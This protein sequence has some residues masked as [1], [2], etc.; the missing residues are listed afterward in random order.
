MWRPQEGTLLA[1]W[2]AATG[3]DVTTAGP[4]LPDDPPIFTEA[5]VD[6]RG[7]VGRLRHALDGAVLREVCVPSP[8]PGATVEAAELSVGRASL[9]L[10]AALTWR[11]DDTC[12]ST[13]HLWRGER[14]LD[15]GAMTGPVGVD[16]PLPIWDVRL[17]TP[18][19]VF[20]QGRSG[21]RVCDVERQISRTVGRLAGWSRDGLLLGRDEAAVTDPRT[22]EEAR[23]GEGG[24][25]TRSMS[26]DGRL[27]ALRR[28][29]GVEWWT[30]VR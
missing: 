20:T 6:A 29:A 24:A 13:L 1:A 22:G 16:E 26:P 10:A 25:Q 4:E 15:L 3:E 23:L 11:L 7:W 9:D 14:R 28:G 8:Q 18:G 19:L 21:R 2:T 27:V 12:S 5:L 17:V 30:I